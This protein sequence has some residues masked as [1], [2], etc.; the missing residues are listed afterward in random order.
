M[1]KKKANNVEIRNIIN[2]NKDVIVVNYSEKHYL[3]RLF[4][5]RRSHS[6]IFDHKL[7]KCNFMVLIFWEKCNFIMPV[8][9]KSVIL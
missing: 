4:R 1:L 3:L 6:D 8:F 5:I 2:K 7:K 9:G